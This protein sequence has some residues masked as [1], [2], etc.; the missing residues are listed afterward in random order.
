VLWVNDVRPH[1]FTA[2]DVTLVQALADQAALAIDHARLVRRGQDAAVLEE[3][4]RLARD[5]HDSVTQS[6]FSLG[7]LA[8]AAQTQHERRS[9]A[10]DGTLDRIA[11][12]SQDALKEMRALLFELQP[13]GLAE[14]GLAAALEKLVAAFR[15]RVDLA[16]T[17]YGDTDLR[18]PADVETAVFRIVQEALNNAAKH[19]RATE[20]TVTVAVLED[21]LR[22]TVEDDGV[23][24]DMEAPA[25]EADGSSGLGMRSMRDRAAAAGLTLRVTSSPGRGTLVSVEAPLPEEERMAA[26]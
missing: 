9:P 3:R 18:L 12:L 25:G 2:E 23:G 7:M 8:K 22:V 11:Q 4:T 15:V 20:V 26:R 1:D 21:R 5:L 19:A 14:E 16:V 13:T 10:L 17:L 24:F 6:V